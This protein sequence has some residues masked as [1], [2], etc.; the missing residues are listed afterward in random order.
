[1]PPLPQPLHEVGLRR[2]GR[3]AAL[4]GALLLPAFLRSVRTCLRCTMLEVM[5]QRDTRGVAC[6]TL[7]C[8][9]ITLPCMPDVTCS[10]VGTG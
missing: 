3:P 2:P 4:S 5:Q 7:A 6:F 9:T 1:M 10:L 8:F